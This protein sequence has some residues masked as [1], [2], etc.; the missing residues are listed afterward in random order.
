MIVCAY[1]ENKHEPAPSYLLTYDL[2]IDNVY[3]Y[4]YIPYVFTQMRDTQYIYYN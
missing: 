3:L 4:E 1:D 2:V